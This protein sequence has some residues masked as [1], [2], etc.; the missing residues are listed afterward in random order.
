MSSTRNFDIP[1][2]RR[3]NPLIA[4]RFLRNLAGLDC[5]E[6]KKRGGQEKGRK[7]QTN[8]LLVLFLVYR[9]TQ[10]SVQANATMEGSRSAISRF[11]ENFIARPSSTYDSGGWPS[12]GARN[13]ATMWCH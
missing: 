9:N 5:T 10:A 11:P 8:D 7:K 6:I 3:S 13:A 12:S 2:A 4:C 1:A